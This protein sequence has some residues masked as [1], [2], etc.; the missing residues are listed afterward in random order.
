MPEQLKEDKRLPRLLAI[1][2]ALVFTAIFLYLNTRQYLTFSLQAPDIDRFDQALWNT[3][4]GR[5]LFSSIP[6]KSIL[7]Y[8]FSP[9]MARR[10][11]LVCGANRRYRRHRP[12]TF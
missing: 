4:R 2:L 11:D 12:D 1:G 5:F 9:Y 10:T 8:H 7:A 6:N 3:L